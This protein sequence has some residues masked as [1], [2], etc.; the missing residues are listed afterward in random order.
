MEGRLLE[1]FEVVA[2]DAGDQCTGG[3]NFV[4]ARPRSDV[5]RDYRRIIEEAYAPAAYFHRVLRVGE[6]LDCRGKRLRLPARRVLLDLRSFA[7]LAW[8]MGVRGRNRRLFWSTLGKLVRRNPRSLRYSIAL[9][10]LY[11]H[12]G[13]F[14]DFLL[15]RLDAAIRSAL[16]TVPRIRTGASDASAG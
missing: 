9:M 1:D 15:V 10:A 16:E 5:L 14:R 7:R 3:L 2:Q 12:F 4:T 8:R 13:K 6:A 11:L